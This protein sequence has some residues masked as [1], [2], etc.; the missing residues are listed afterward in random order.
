MHG[1]DNMVSV[2]SDIAKGNHKSDNPDSSE[3]TETSDG[4][5]LHSAHAKACALVKLAEDGEADEKFSKDWVKSKL[6]AADKSLTAI[7]DFIVHDKEATDTNEHGDDVGKSGNMDGG[8]I[9]S[10]ERALK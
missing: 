10:I 5:A 7:H 1:D 8:F 2:D 4:D 9:I 3:D 6:A